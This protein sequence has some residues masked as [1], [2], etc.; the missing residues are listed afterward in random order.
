MSVDPIQ[1]L[2]AI[3]QEME[4]HLKLRFARRQRFTNIIELKIIFVESF[5]FHMKK[6]FKVYDVF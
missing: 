4:K 1:R 3:F 5:K 6:N 2:E